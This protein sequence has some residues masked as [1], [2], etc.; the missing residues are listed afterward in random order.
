M[1]RRYLLERSAQ[2]VVTV[3]TVITLTFVL[4]KQIPGGPTAYLKAQLA[5]SGNV[6]NIE[7]INELVEAY[8]GFRNTAPLHQQYIDYIS[9][10]FL[11]GDLGRSLWYN[12]PVSQIYAAAVPWTVFVLGTAILLNFAIIVVVG[13][14]VAY[15]EGS[16]TDYL[17][18]GVFQVVGSVP[19]YI[20]AIVLLFVLGYNYGMFPTGGRVSGD[21]SAGLNVPFLRS[22]AYHAALPMASVV[23]AQ[24]GRMLT[25]RANSISVL[26]EDY[27]R[28]ARLRGLSRGRIARTYVARN[29]IL[30]MYTG[31][32]ITL[33]SVF[34]GSVILEQIF[35]YRGAGFYLFNA[36]V[37][38]D[39]ILMMGG[40][41][42]ITV[43]VIVGV[44]V[45]DL[46][47]GMIDPT[48][49]QTG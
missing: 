14:S 40:F 37:H 49:D 2:A 17:L 9:S 10:V 18:S 20:V 26:G 42:L 24:L 35:G 19:Y 41:L 21:V 3:F 11:Q 44:F 34:G 13:A 46:T 5:A 47:Y 22:V 15:A 8:T 23:I 7:R 48:V 12:E 45:A 39:Y 32:I 33:G 6:D 1:N 28:V 38:R 30:P 43:A 16:R 4:I 36:V 27:L 31:L 29:A 25:M